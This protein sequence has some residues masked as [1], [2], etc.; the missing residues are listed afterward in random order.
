MRHRRPDRPATMTPELME[1]WAVDTP[2]PIAGHP[3]VRVERPHPRPG[4]G[5]IR[6]EVRVC[7]VCRTDLHLAEGDLAPKRPLVV[8]GHEVVGTVDLVGADCVRFGEGARVGIPW[9]AHT[10]GECRFCVTGRENLCVAP[11]FTGWDRRRWICGLRGRRRAVRVPDSS[12]HSPTTRPPRCCAPGS[13]ATAPCVSP[14][15]PP[16][17]RLGIYGFGGSA[18]LTAQVAIAEGARVHV[19]T[20]RPKRARCV[21]ARRDQRRGVPTTPRPSRSTPPSCSHR[22]ALWCSPPWPPSNAGGPWRS[23]GST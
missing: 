18:H 14:G 9:L 19:L 1:A 12:A 8:P 23:P 20:R 10:C 7:G 13:S 2:G 5:Q 3:L 4:P 17:G 6:V 22:S 11:L 15:L 21:A 16:G